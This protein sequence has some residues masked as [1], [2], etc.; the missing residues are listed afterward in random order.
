VLKYVAPSSGGGTYCVDVWSFYRVMEVGSYSLKV[1]LQSPT[2]DVR[3][4]APNVPKTVWIN[5]DYTSTGTLSPR[6]FPGDESILLD[7]Q[8]YSDG[9]WRSQET[10]RVENEDYGGITRYTAEYSFF[11]WGSGEMKWRVRAVHCADE[12]HPTRPRSG[13]R[14]G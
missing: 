8:K 2:N 12:L 1:D 4:T 14:S 3:V 13:A 6:H 11:G 9:R 10:Q 7:C 5:E